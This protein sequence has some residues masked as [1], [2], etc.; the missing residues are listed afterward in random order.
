MGVD[1]AQL[2]RH[3]AFIMDGNGRWAR[4][5]G[6]NRTY[7]HRAGVKTVREL[8]KACRAIGVQVMTV[9]AFSTENWRRP[10]DEVNFLMCLFEDVIKNELKELASN[11]VQ[12]RFIGERSGL[13]TK[14]QQIMRDAEI[15]TAAN[16]RLILNV[17]INYGGRNEILRAVARIAE[18]ARLGQIAPEAIDEALFDSHLDTAGQPDPDLVIRTGGEARLSNYLLWQLAYAEIYVTDTMW[19]EF[20]DDGLFRAI[21]DY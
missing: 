10:G 9:F 14:L 20:G 13:S 2:P 21:V 5:Q 12:I 19:P 11:S 15:E 18:Q 17:A 7:G 1:V 8:V 16:N 3:I 4:R 6:K